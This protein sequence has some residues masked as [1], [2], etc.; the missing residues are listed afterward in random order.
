MSERVLIR[1]QADGQLSWV[2]QDASGRVLSGATAGVPPTQVLARAQ[3]IIALVPAEAVLLLETPRIAGGAAQFRKAVPF[4]L[5]D[6]LAGSV[7]DLHFAIPE[8]ASGDHV[9]VAV[10]A[11]ATLVDWATRLASE[12]IRADAMVAETQALPCSDDSACILIED[13]RVLWRIAPAQAGT[14]ELSAL[15]DW[16]QAIAAIDDNPR[17]FAVYD[18]RDAGPLELPIQPI[19]Y[20]RNQ[21]DVLAFFA[22]HMANEPTLNLLQGEFAPAHRH[23]PTKRLWRNAIA[24]V[25][26]AIILAFVYYGVDYWRLSRESARLDAAAHAIL[27]STFP[28]MDKVAGD[29]RQLMQSAMRGMNANG[30]SGGL[31]PLLGRIA[32][33]LGSTTR[34]SLTGMEYHNDSLEL[35]MRAP[36][37]QTLDRMRESLDNLSGLDVELTAVNSGAT[38]IEGRIRINRSKP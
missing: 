22:A 37:V 38:G 16:L 24:L 30:E 15:P 35:A 7:E 3:R 8:R 28:R 23:A 20:H 26:A 6:Q 17:T 31:L 21:H 4:A 11:R 1:L 18:F 34:T 9:A 29:P 25:A 32:P 33:I 13:E 12:G 19:A 27:H 2:T 5:E 10:V 36:D 14:C